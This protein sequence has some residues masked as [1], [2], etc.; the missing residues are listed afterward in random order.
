MG[1]VE[2]QRH[3]A[4]ARLRMFLVAGCLLWAN[5]AKLRDLPIGPPRVPKPGPTCGRCG[6]PYAR[7]YGISPRGMAY[8]HADGKECRMEAP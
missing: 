4:A 6:K 3:A 8:V 1:M 5:R 2:D 7:A